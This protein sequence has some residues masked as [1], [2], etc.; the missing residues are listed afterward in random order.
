[1]GW[2][3]FLVS[4]VLIVAGIVMILTPKKLVKL[5]AE[6]LG[7]KEPRRFGLIPLFV[8]ILLLFSVPFSAVGWL[9]VLLGLA[10]IAKAVYIF[11]APIQK[12]KS[13]QWFALSDNGHRALGILILIVGVIIFISRL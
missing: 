8:G 12:I 5:A 10:E 7:G 9:I 6:L 2:Y 4:L 11:L 1:M 13:H 3:L